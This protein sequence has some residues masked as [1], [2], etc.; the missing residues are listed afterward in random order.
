MVRI[1]DVKCPG[2]GEADRRPWPN[3][4][5]L[6]SRDEV[7]FMIADRA[8]YKYAHNVG[9]HHRCGEGG[10]ACGRCCRRDVRMDVPV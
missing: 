3:L 8:D 2:S 4:H 6:T 7:K 5:E 1:L 9:L 10:G